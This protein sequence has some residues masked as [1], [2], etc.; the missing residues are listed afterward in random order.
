MDG[1]EWRALVEVGQGRLGDGG[2]E[3]DTAKRILALNLKE[4]NCI[5]YLD[6]HVR[7]FIPQQNHAHTS[8]RNKCILIL[9]KSYRL[10]PT[11]KLI[12][13]PRHTEVRETVAFIDQQV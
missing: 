6:D 7:R 12:H 1:V 11:A 8:E 5:L 4:S 10:P 3:T 9:M 13:R 2:T